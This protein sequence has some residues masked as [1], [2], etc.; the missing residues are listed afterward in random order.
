MNIVIAADSFKGCMSSEQAAE[1][2]AEGIL[3]ANPNHSIQKFP[4][5]DGGEGLSLIHI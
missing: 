5:A 3:R 1:S 2:I 4:A